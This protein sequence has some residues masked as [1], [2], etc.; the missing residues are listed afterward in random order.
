LFEYMFANMSVNG[1]QRV[2][3]QIDVSA[4]NFSHLFDFRN[5]ML[6]KNRDISLPVSIKCSRHGDSLSLS[7]RKIDASLANFRVIS[8]R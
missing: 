1:T 4:C 2:I 7:A 6:F 3:Q 5:I 8:C